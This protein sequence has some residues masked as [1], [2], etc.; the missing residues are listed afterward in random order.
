MNRE[1]VEE[2]RRNSTL[3]G[4]HPPDLP[5]DKERICTTF[6]QAK[7]ASKQQTIPLELEDFGNPH[8]VFT[9][10]SGEGLQSINIHGIKPKSG[11][12]TCLPDFQWSSRSK[13]S[14][15]LDLAWI[16]DRKLPLS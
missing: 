11:M 12:Y 5:E 10:R 8:Q 16:N 2:H 15:G 9:A 13:E 7:C 3:I 6:C 1:E 4:K 14:T